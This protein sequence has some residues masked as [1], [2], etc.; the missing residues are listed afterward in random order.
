VNGYEGH[1]KA[2]FIGARHSQSA[3]QFRIMVMD[4]LI[5]RLRSDADK[6][7][8]T[9]RALLR[10]AADEIE[11]LRCLVTEIDSGED[12]KAFFDALDEKET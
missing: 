8:P 4:D 10:E 5:K 9:A 1:F 2:Y 3:R 11:R 12:R 6:R 7:W